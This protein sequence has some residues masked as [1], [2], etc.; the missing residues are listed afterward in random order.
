[1]ERIIMTIST[2]NLN[3]Y[4]GKSTGSIW[5]H[6]RAWLRNKRY[7]EIA[8]AE[9]LFFHR[10]RWDFAVTIGFGQG[11]SDNFMCF[12]IALPWLL[13]I[14][15]LVPGWHCQKPCKT[16]LAIHNGAL[17]LYLLPFDMESN[18]KDPWWRKSY[19]WYFPWTLDWYSTEIFSKDSFFSAYGYEERVIWSENRKNRKPFFEGYD[20]RK[21]AEAQASNVYDFTYTLKNGEVQKRKATIRTERMTHVARWWPLIPRKQTVT[22]IWI[23][24]DDEVGEKT[25]SWKGGC[26]G[27]GCTM[28][29]GETP[30]STLRRMESERKF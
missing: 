29:P 3:E 20:E 28:L 13:S 23:D 22:S 4:P 15:F 14:Y 2:Q 6:G 30:L 26:T 17:W 27:C 12:H 8:H 10:V 7:H 24:F 25:G 19:S 21:A 5:S 16:G 11:D 9:W 18:S 1:M